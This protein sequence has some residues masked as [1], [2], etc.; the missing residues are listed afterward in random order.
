MYNRSMNKLQYTSTLTIDKVLTAIFT[1]DPH[2]HEGAHEM[3][4]LY[5]LHKSGLA[6]DGVLQVQLDA[7]HDAFIDAMDATSHLLEQGVAHDC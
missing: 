6:E 5:I 3:I 1:A 7:A 4:T 2:D